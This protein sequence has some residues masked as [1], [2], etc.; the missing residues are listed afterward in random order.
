MSGSPVISRDLCFTKAGLTD[1]R[2]PK[3]IEEMLVE[4]EGEEAEERGELGGE[5]GLKEVKS[6]M[7]MS[8]TCSQTGSVAATPLKSKAQ[9]NFAAKEVMTFC[10][11]LG[12]HE[13]AFYGDN[14]PTIRSVL[15]ILWNTLGLR[16]RILTSRI[17]D[18]AGNSLTENAEERVGGLTCT[19]I[20]DLM[21]RIQ[22]R[23]TE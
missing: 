16:T 21:S 2:D 5:I 13:V 8:I 23:L 19:I 17:R 20:E 15:K 7:W 18:S 14:E 11:H 10:Q 22:V 6:A 12:H 3:E 9:I 4:E 1:R